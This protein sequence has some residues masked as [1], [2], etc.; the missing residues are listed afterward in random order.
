MVLIAITMSFSIPNIR[1]SL[2]TDQLKATARKLVGLINETSQQTYLSG[3]PRILEYDPKN[4]VFT[5]AGGG[6]TS[7][8]GKEVPTT[9]DVPNAVIVKDI[10]TYHGGA[11]AGDNPQ[12]RFTKNGYVDM[13]LIHLEEDGRE[14]TLYLPPFLGAIA[15][16][17]G[18]QDFDSEVLP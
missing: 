11:E 14:L 4:R 2:Y 5:V 8:T 1:G 3:I 17:D 12:V 18:Y 13:T 9:L 7:L 15:I 10:L 16:Y 6:G